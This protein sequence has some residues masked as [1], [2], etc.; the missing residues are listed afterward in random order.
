MTAADSSEA[1]DWREGR[2][3]RGYELAEA[4]WQ[5]KE[6]AEA[7]GVSEG[8]VSQ[9]MK[10]AREGGVASL[11]RRLAPGAESK[12]SAE[13]LARLP[14]VLSQGAEAYG[15]RGSVWTYERIRAVIEREFG[16]HYHVDHMNFILKKIGWSRQKPRKRAAQ[17]DEKA[18]VQWQDDWPT[19]EKK[20]KRRNKR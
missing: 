12:L 9:W 6:I 5:Q 10:R 19:I 8:A 4:G 14:A 20:P 1:M 11:K 17:R 2:R 13:Q 15:F 7:F 16:I 18:I 3:L